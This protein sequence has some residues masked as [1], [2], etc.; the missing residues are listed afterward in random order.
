[1]VT[2]TIHTDNGASCAIGDR[3]YYSV[4][5]LSTAKYTVGKYVPFMCKDTGCYLKDAFDIGR[6]RGYIMSND[7]LWSD[8]RGDLAR[9][10]LD[11]V[12]FV[13][14]PTT[15]DVV[16]YIPFFDSLVDLLG[17]DG[18]YDSLAKIVNG[19]VVSMSRRHKDFVLRSVPGLDYHMKGGG[20]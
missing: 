6:D 1:M 7:P 14:A 13:D 18:A 11:Y 9:K 4:R 8:F 16:T 3:D 5:D 10:M 15:S 12:A 20:K 19:D 17:K 2:K